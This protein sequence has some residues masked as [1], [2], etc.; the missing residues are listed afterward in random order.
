MMMKTTFFSCVWL[1]EADIFLLRVNSII[2]IDKCTQRTNERKT[3]SSAPNVNDHVNDPTLI[4]CCEDLVASCRD[5]EVAAAGLVRQLYVTSR[6]L[7][8]PGSTGQLRAGDLGEE[9]NA[10][11]IYFDA[12]ENAYC[13]SRNG[14]PPRPREQVPDRDIGALL[15]SFVRDNASTEP[16]FITITD[17]DLRRGVETVRYVIPARQIELYCEHAPE[18][19]LGRFPKATTPSLVPGASLAIIAAILVLCAIVYV[20]YLRPAPR[21]PA[22]PPSARPYMLASAQETDAEVAAIR[23]ALHAPTTR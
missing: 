17:S 14:N 18:C 16:V 9:I 20:K 23:A 22:L 11:I 2:H 5:K 21:A 7:G 10:R 15:R 1:H 4:H 13:V 6:P 3:M 19:M 12:R 8:P